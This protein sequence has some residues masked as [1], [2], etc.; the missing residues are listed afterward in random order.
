V[1][2]KVSVLVSLG[3]G[4]FLGLFSLPVEA[5]D[6]G[7]SSAVNLVGTIPERGSYLIVDDSIAKGIKQNFGIGVAQ[8]LYVTPLRPLTAIGFERSEPK[9]Y[10]HN[11]GHSY[12]HAEAHVSIRQLAMEGVVTQTLSFS[13]YDG[14]NH[15]LASTQVI[16]GRP[17]EWQSFNRCQDCWSV[18]PTKFGVIGVAQSRLLKYIPFNDPTKTLELS[19]RSTLMGFSSKGQNHFYH[20]ATNTL[21][22][23]L[24][25][26]FT[27]KTAL[28]VISFRN[29]QPF[30]QFVRAENKEVNFLPEGV[31]ELVG[32][33]SS[34]RGQ[35]DWTRLEFRKDQASETPKLPEKAKP[36]PHI[37]KSETTIEVNGQKYPS[38]VDLAQFFDPRV[39]QQFGGVCHLNSAADLFESACIKYAGV[40]PSLSVAYLIYYHIRAELENRGRHPLDAATVAETE[41]ER[42]FTLFDGGFADKS[43][44]YIAVDGCVCSEK[45][46]PLANDLLDYLRPLIKQSADEMSRA[47]AGI[48][49]EMATKKDP[50]P[51]WTAMRNRFK[52]DLTGFFERSFCRNTCRSLDEYV[53][54][55]KVPKTMTQKGYKLQTQ[56]EQL[57]TCLSVLKEKQVRLSSPTPYTPELALKLLSGG[58]PFVCGGPLNPT[59]RRFETR[60]DKW[61]HE[62]V[63][64]GYNAEST[65][66]L[67][68][69]FKVRDH[70]QGKEAWGWKIRDCTIQYYR[71]D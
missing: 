46:F 26:L 35:M 42:F 69:D 44:N 32:A 54:R 5:A 33:S 7:T 11:L 18:M 12:G 41:K 49:R 47:V 48:E 13:T 64:N 39:K 17:G 8:G 37:H 6:R 59:E 34:E 45:E 63:F 71:Q 55:L 50:D 1:L 24:T 70:T 10:T 16:D 61:G 29:E 4:G 3:F 30:I 53:N 28:A 38:H 27:Q 25:N 62:T 19:D 66:P 2:L 36:L 15:F 67:V 9:S 23:A 60:Q 57:L 51:E 14:G 40:S 20:A 21:A 68:L 22:L 58:T 31:I 43:L 65:N 52:D 56:D